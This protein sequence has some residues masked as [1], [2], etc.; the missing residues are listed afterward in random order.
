NCLVVVSGNGSVW[1]NQL[2]LEFGYKDHN[3]RMIIEAGGLVSCDNG[4]MNSGGDLVFGTVPINNEVLV[5]GPGSLWTNRSAIELNNALVGGFSRLVVSNG[6]AVAAGG[7]GTVGG[8]GNRVFI[9][10]AGSRYAMRSELT[11]GGADNQLAVSD[12]AAM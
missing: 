6:A 7:T 4:R 3:N 12:G 5:T 2:D 10:G 11:I 1:S 9:T 8:T